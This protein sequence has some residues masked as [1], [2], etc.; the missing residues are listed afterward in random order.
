MNNR[1]REI[2]RD[3]AKRIAE[4]AKQ[5]IME[6]RRNKWY[7]HNDLKSADP[8]ILVFPEGGWREI[9]TPDMLLCE[10][11]EARFM[12][13]MLRARLFRAENINDDSV[14]EGIWETAKCI[15]NTG[16]GI[17]EGAG[18]TAI[19]NEWVVDDSIGYCPSVW[20]KDFKFVENAMTF[21]PCIDDEDDLK[22]LR[23]PE[24][25]YDEKTTLERL[26]LH[27]DV[28]GDILDVR[29]VGKKYIMFNLVE[30]YTDHRGLENVLYDL[31]EEPEMTHKAMDIF[32][33]GFRDMVRQY[34][35]MGLLEMNNDHSYCGS[36]GVGY[37][38]ELPKDEN[39]TKSLKNLWAFA[40]SQ[41][42]TNVSPA[43]HKEF[44]MEHEARLLEPFGLSAYGCC[45][46]L[47]RK[48]D[49][50]L[51]MPNMR[52]ISISPW[53]DI[54][55][56]AEQMRMKAVY[57]WKPNPSYFINNFEESF[58]KEYVTNMLKH[59]K[60]NAAEIVL[61]DTHTCMHEPQRYRIWTDLVRRCIEETR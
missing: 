33:N 13:W 20:K 56:C 5:P 4:L 7:A 24:I 23:T 47:E 25:I 53:A 32:E 59:T 42:F 37:T 15:S 11:E 27:Q 8:M 43:Q 38:H 39:G 12:E 26:A 19:V 55:S 3:L 16:W 29:L 41:E 9:I 2:I 54:Q 18:T 34:H 30:M 60:N 17:R 36:G 45:E 52:R 61:K 31:Y 50:V 49:D 22:K 35:E 51:N 48:L 10:D 14:V 57:S 6:E 28:L 44:V 1:E 46:P 21:K 40:E 58:L